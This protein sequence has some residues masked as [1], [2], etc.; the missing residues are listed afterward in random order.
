MGAIGIASLITILSYGSL[1]ESA[2]I[3]A[4]VIFLVAGVLK[5]ALSI[6]GIFPVIFRKKFLFAIVSF[7]CR[8]FVRQIFMYVCVCTYI[9]WYI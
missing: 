8:T 1:V 3:A 4:P 2:F 6:F 5:V 7:C 9:E